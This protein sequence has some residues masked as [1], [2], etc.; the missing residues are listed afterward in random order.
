MTRA[1]DAWSGHDTGLILA[2][3]LVPAIDK[4]VAG[5]G[6]ALPAR[7]PHVAQQEQFPSAESRLELKAVLS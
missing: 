2:R 4:P 7:L 6:M 5:V 1:G 3:C